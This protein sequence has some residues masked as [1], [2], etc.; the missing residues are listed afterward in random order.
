MHGFVPC[1]YPLFLVVESGRGNLDAKLRLLTD[2]IECKMGM[3]VVI[4]LNFSR[5]VDRGFTVH[6]FNTQH[7]MQS[8]GNFTT[9]HR[10][11]RHCSHYG[12]KTI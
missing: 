3:Q 7:V 1:V 6:N 8:K 10:N 5:I 9:R 12:T 11:R 2:G 4:A